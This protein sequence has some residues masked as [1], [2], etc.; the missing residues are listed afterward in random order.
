M[1]LKDAE[2]NIFTSK[3]IKTAVFLVVAAIAAAAI[4]AAVNIKKQ[5]VDTTYLV[6]TL[7]K[8]SELTSAKLNYTGMTKFEDEGIPFINK[9]SF[10]M[11]YK[12]T[13]RAGI[14]VKEITFKDDNLNKTLY[15]TIPKAKVLDVKVDAKSVQFFD[16]KFA[17]LN[18]NEKEDGMKA[19]SLAEEAAKDEVAN[20]GILEM[21]DEQAEV[22]IKGLIQESLPKGYKIRVKK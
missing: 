13:A 16:T 12:A 14:D 22:L 5:T 11:I 18:V 4:S 19:L 17:L 21:A 2:K 6:S 3:I 20:M 15:I 7:E 10:S 8:S 1:K 9:S